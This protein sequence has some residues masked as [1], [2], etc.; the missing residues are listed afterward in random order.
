M[1]LTDNCRYGEI[2]RLFKKQPLLTGKPVFNYLRIFSWMLLGFGVVG[3]LA[4]MAGVKSR[5][6][7]ADTLAAIL[8]LQTLVAAC[9]VYGFRLYRQEKISRGLLLRAGWGL[10]VLL[11]LVGQIWLNLG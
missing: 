1:A 6:G 11:A 4:L 10:I 2:F 7:P 9:I 3:L 8:L 5:I